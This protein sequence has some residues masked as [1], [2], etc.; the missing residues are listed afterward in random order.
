MAGFLNSGDGSVQVKIRSTLRDFLWLF[1][2][3]IMRLF[4]DLLGN[5]TD[6]SRPNYR[7]SGH[8]EGSVQGQTAE[9]MSLV[10][11]LIRGSFCEISV[12][13]FGGLCKL[14]CIRVFLANWT[15]RTLIVRLFKNPAMW[16]RNCKKKSSKQPISL[17]LT[18]SEDDDFRLINISTMEQWIG[19][20]SLDTLFQSG[21]HT[22]VR[23]VPSWVLSVLTHGN[24]RR[25][26]SN[27]RL[28]IFCQVFSSFE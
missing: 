12:S 3:S 9:L 18:C 6:L 7:A 24:W 26:S 19:T 16:W 21:H 22:H 4:W 23:A 25:R 14:A 2:V 15:D 1:I 13:D 27:Y 17:T 10:S 20:P 11:C 8:R 5:V 28:R